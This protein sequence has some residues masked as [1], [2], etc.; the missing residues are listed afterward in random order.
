VLLSMGRQLRLGP[1]SRCLFWVIRAI[2][3]KALPRAADCGHDDLTI[4]NTRGSW[5]DLGRLAI[6][7]PV[8]IKFEPRLRHYNTDIETRR[9]ETS[10]RNWALG[11]KVR[12]IGLQRLH[13]IVLT[14]GNIASI[15]TIRTRRTETGLAG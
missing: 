2:S 12:K 4:A 11:S 8:S 9:P 6:V 13:I 1:Y 15:L 7:K 3:T 14:R 10:V 5:R